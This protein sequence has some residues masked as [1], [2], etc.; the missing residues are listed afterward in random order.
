MSMAAMREQRHAEE[1]GNILRL[2][3]E[4]YTAVQITVG[5]LFHSMDM[6][7]Y[8]VSPEALRFHLQYLADQGYVQ[9]AR[10]RDMPGWRQDRMPL[11]SPDE[12]RFAKLL[13]RGLML[14]DGR[15]D[16]DPMVRF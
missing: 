8:T 11:G 16:E 7:G 10:N 1:R 14:L 2:L 12:I 4:E 3:K 6:S 9:I 15:I 13:P 5:T